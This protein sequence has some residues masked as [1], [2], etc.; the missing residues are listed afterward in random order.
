MD[1][2][3][4]GSATPHNSMCVGTI[5]YTNAN[6]ETQDVTELKTPPGPRAFS[7]HTAEMQHDAD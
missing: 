5:S 7:P 2:L 1:R 6:E 3:A 4:K